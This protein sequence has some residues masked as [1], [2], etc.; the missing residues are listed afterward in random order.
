ML[1]QSL[2]LA[3]RLPYI[4]QMSMVSDLHISL[5]AEKIFEIPLGSFGVIEV[6]NSMFTGWLVSLFVSLVL[7]TIVSTFKKVPRGLQ[8]LYESVFNFVYGTIRDILGEPLTSKIFPL[9]F[10]IFLFV[11]FGS[12][13]GLLPGAGTLGF[14]ND[15]NGT[16]VPV[17]I[18]RAVTADINT[19]IALALVSVLV[20][21][22]FGFAYNGFGYLKKFFNFSNPVN[23]FVGILEFV[24]EL[25]RIVTFSFRLFGNIFAGEVILAVMLMLAGYLM[26]PFLAFEVFVGVVQALVFV[27]LTT[28]FISLAVEKVEHH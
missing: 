28:V 1:C 26:F 23:F 20:I 6:T 2:L 12:W 8:G 19:T 10:T 21:E 22:Y 25:M 16:P 5:V 3:W 14:F 7:L 17:P 18:F 4:M 27:M 15:Y 24:S 9:L 13:A 11:M